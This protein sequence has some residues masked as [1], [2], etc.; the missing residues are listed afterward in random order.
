MKKHIFNLLHGNI[1]ILVAIRLGRQRP[2][3]QL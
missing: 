1:A 3:S 2:V